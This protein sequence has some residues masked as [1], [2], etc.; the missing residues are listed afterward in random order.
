MKKVFK[1]FILTAIVAAFG[2]NAMGQVS[3]TNTAGARIIAPIAIASN[4]NMHFGTIMRGTAGSTILLTPGGARSV[5][6]GDATLS[7]LAPA[8]AAGSFT[9]TGEDGLVYTIALPADGTVTLTGPGPAMAVNSFTSNP[10]G[11]GTLTGGTSTLTVGAT[12]SVAGPTQTSGAYSGTFDVT[13]NY[14]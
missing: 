10:S 4:V 14:Q 11:T 13:V 7:A 6:T 1:F 9:V 3:A 5:A 2:V 8:H 12:L